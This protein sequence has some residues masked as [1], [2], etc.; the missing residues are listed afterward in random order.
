M[1]MFFIATVTSGMYVQADLVMLGFLGTTNMV[2][3]YQLVIKI[4]GTFLTAVNSV[5]NVMLQD[6]LIITRRKQRRGRKFWLRR[7]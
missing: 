7:L 2:G 6:Y 1:L 4:K 3:I 5:G